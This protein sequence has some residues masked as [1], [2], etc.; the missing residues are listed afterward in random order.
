MNSKAEE[1]Y[2]AICAILDRLYPYRPPVEAMEAIAH[3]LIPE[4]KAKVSLFKRSG[5]WYTDEQ[6][7]I[8]EQCTVPA[9]MTKSPD[10]HRIDS[11][12]VLV[13]TQEPWG[14]PHLL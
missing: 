9:E 1:N 4:W 8:P 10:F 14:F 13:H 3:R 7:E 12:L 6:W 5:K 2:E 11:G